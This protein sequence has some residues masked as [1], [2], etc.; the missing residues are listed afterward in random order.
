MEKN[1]AP[2]KP[3]DT[4]KPDTS[5]GKEAEWYSDHLEEA[6]TYHA[7]VILP[8]VERIVGAR[9]GLKIL[10]IGCGEGFIARHLAKTGAEV[11]ACDISRELIDIGKEKGGNVTY[12]VSKAEDLEW[13]TAK[14]MDTVLAVLTLQNMERIEPV[15]SGVARVLKSDGRFVF[16]LNHPVFRIPGK[17]SWGFDEEKYVQYRR[18]DVYLSQRRI[19]IDMHP[20]KK[21]TKSVT[22]SFHRSLQDYMKALNS[23]GFSI[24][25]LEEW[26]SHRISEKGPRSKAEDAARKEFPLFLMVECSKIVS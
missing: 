1:T 12:K 10:E 5:W 19:E 16:I 9:K 11:T 13:V 25:R 23:A 8:N 7:K 24:V 21:D 14:S 17:T 6:D 4:K 20:G 26:I 22:Y 3:Q 2:K 15:F 18:S